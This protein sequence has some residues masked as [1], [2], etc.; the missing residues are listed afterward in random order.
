MTRGMYFEE[1]EPGLE[2]TTPSRTVTESDVFS[3]AGL[4]GDYNQLHTD[5]EF[6]KNTMFGRPIAHGM[7]VLS[8]ATGLAAR[9]GFIEGTALAFRELS[10][11]FSSPVF[12]GDTVHIVARCREKKLMPRLG[13]GIVV[14]D[15]RVVNQEGKVVQRGDWQLLMACQPDP[16]EG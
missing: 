11:K 1:F 2:I 12:F 4:S 15:V 7:L 3:F 8:I 10:W 16:E 9:M 13:G 5:A 14:F 6:A